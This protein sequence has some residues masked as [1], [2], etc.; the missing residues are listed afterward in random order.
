[1]HILHYRLEVQ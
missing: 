1:M